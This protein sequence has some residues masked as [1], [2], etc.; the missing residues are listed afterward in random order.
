M[1]TARI[2]QPVD[3]DDAGDVLAKAE[4]EPLLRQAVNDAFSFASDDDGESDINKPDIAE[5]DAATEAQEFLDCRKKN[6]V[7]TF[8]FWKNAFW[9]WSEAQGKYYELGKSEVE[10]S[11]IRHLNQAF[12]NVHTRATANVLAQVKAMSIVASRKQAPC[13]LEEDDPG[14][15]LTE[16]LVTRNLIVDLRSLRSE[17]NRVKKQTPSLFNMSALEFGF[18]RESQKPRSWLTFLSQLWPD[19]PETIEALQLWFG[20]CLTPDTS[21]QK[22]LAMFG[23]KRAGKGTIARIQTSLL[24]KSNVTGANLGQFNN[25]FGLWPLFGKRLA[26]IADARFSG[27]Q[28]QAPV[29]ERLLSIT[30][31][32]E[33]LIDR[34]YKDPFSARLTTRIA[35]ISNEVPR[36]N[37]ASGALVSRMI[38]LNFRST[39]YGRE[40]TSLEKKLMSELPSILWWAI[41]GWEKLQ[42]RGRLIQP[43]SSLQK[44]QDWE[45]LSSPVKAL[46]R[47]RCDVDPDLMI[48]KSEMFD[49]YQMWCSLNGKKHVDDSA[50]FGKNL[51]AATD[52]AISTTRRRVDGKL[53]WHYTGIGLKLSS[54]DHADENCSEC[55]TKCS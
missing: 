40:D 49:A 32:D 25:N 12:R 55:S 31:E 48:P 37:D 15:S 6:G 2:A 14:W 17:S 46:V 43:E 29:V 24:G 4:G 27:R 23:P 34:K 50:T 3:S 9:Q 5:M 36:L 53:V 19:D 8:R 52:N 18:Q 26:I 13:W 11:I 1:S 45:D 33:Q 20:Y 38:V 44:I 16:T 30:G 47:E 10:A 28:D 51:H 41:K 39:F 21:Q 22:M 54:E 7:F 35:M 42:D